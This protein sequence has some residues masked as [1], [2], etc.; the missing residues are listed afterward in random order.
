MDFEAALAFFHRAF[1][2]GYTLASG[3]AGEGR[4]LVP[5]AV[6]Q[7]ASDFAACFAT[8]F[9]SHRASQEARPGNSS[10]SASNIFGLHRSDSSGFDSQGE[11]SACGS[12]DGPSHAPSATP[13]PGQSHATNAHSSS[14]DS[15]TST[16]RNVATVTCQAVTHV[17]LHMGR[18]NRTDL[19][20]EIRTV[21]HQI[22]RVVTEL[23]RRWDRLKACR[24]ER[25]QLRLST[26]DADESPTCSVETGAGL[27]DTALVQSSQFLHSLQSRLSRDF[28]YS[29]K[30][31]ELYNQKRLVRR[32][33]RRL[34]ALIRRYLELCSRAGVPES[35][36]RLI[37]TLDVP[38][39]FDIY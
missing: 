24:E 8:Q 22:P 32:T 18:P 13:T 35:L 27:V 37:P 34:E 38:L 3:Q 17:L 16:R 1:L 2:A 26:Q 21:E 19:L 9:A 29:D 23:H 39:S 30:C 15:R 6:P 33:T 11:F 5:Q 10:A 14:S 25:D 20:R 4:E 28:E 36:R 7:Y 31:K 12:S